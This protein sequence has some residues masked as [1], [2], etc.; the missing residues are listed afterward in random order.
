MC[1][2]QIVLRET[3]SDCVMT[4][5]FDFGSVTSLE[6]L[7]DA[8]GHVKKQTHLPQCFLSMGQMID[9]VKLVGN[10]ERSTLQKERK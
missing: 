5:A 10:V 4:K 6:S 1:I 3:S 8:G 7:D 2:N 9:V